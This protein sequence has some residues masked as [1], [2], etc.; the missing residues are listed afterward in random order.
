MLFR[1]VGILLLDL[2]NRRRKVE[3]R[4]KQVNVMKL[5]RD[6]VFIFRPRWIGVCQQE[7]R[8]ASF[9]IAD[10]LGDVFV[11]EVNETIA[12]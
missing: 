10:R 7:R 12:T 2:S 9:E 8:S 3:W 6:D 11:R 4:Q 1:F 5:S